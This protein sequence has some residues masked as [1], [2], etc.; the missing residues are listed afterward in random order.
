[1]WSETEAGWEKPQH[2]IEKS[3]P[4]LFW[5]AAFLWLECLVLAEGMKRNGNERKPFSILFRGCSTLLAYESGV[6]AALKELSPNMVKS[7]SKIYG[8]SSGSIVATFGLCGCDLGKG[9]ALSFI[10]LCLK[11]SYVWKPWSCKRSGLGFL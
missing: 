2:S 7:A 3:L 11:R 1:M 5:T 4:D 6:L 8:A 9:F 10:F